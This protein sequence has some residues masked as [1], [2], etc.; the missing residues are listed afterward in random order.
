M[1]PMGVGWRAVAVIID[2]VVLFIIGYAV[3]LVTGGT[4]ATGF[5]MTGVPALFT[6]FLWVAYYIG[7]EALFGATLGKMV[8]GLRVIKVDGTAIGWQEAIVRNVL[9]VVDGRI[10][11]V[12]SQT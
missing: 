5:E 3:A 1:Q 10:A 11:R 9:R 7:M 8:L 2:F 6:F 12:A 4:T